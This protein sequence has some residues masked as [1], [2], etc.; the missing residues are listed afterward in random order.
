VDSF[1]Q[2]DSSADSFTVIHSD[3]VGHCSLRQLV[4]FICNK[5]FAPDFYFCF[6]WFRISTFF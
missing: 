4:S 2:Q 3:S 5:S 6:K 1:I